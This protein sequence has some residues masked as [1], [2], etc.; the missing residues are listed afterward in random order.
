MKER[1]SRY[2]RITRIAYQIAQESLPLY[3]HPKSSHHYTFPQPAACVLLMF[4][5]DLPYR[6]M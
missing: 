1:E 3:K 5:L 4:Y 6:D 2:V